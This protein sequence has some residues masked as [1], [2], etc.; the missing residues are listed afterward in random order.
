MT[1]MSAHFTQ[2]SCENLTEN[3]TRRRTFLGNFAGKNNDRKV[4]RRGAGRP[5]HKQTRYSRSESTVY[6][7][8]SCPRCSHS[9]SLV[10][11]SSSGAGC[12]SSTTINA[13]LLGEPE[14]FRPENFR[15]ENENKNENGAFSLFTE[16]HDSRTLQAARPTAEDRGPVTRPGIGALHSRHTQSVSQMHAFYE[17]NN[18]EPE[19]HH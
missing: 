14:N 3:E 15:T 7:T 5:E 12:T 17:Q 6:S 16:N 4:A 10:R 18:G 11:S 9:P 19:N 2:G 13:V 8:W 1:H